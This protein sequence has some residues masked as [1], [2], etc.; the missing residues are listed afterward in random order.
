MTAHNDDITYAGIGGIFT[1]LWNLLTS[2]QIWEALIM[3][4]FGTLGGILVREAY[5]WLK[6]KWTGKKS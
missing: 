5:K 2:G 4:V 3:G 6:K 1:F